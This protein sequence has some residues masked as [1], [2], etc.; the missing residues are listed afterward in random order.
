MTARQN[1]NGIMAKKP[2]NEAR[3]RLLGRLRR[4]KFAPFRY[5]A[6]DALVARVSDSA[7]A[8]PAVQARIDKMLTSR[9]YPVGGGYLVKLPHDGPSVPRD[10][11]FWVE[12]GGWDHEHCDACN[13][14][15]LVGGPVWCT[16]RGS[17]Q[18]LCPYCYRR[19]AQLSRA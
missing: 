4:R 11:G 18:K 2:A 16:V 7:P 8:P 14:P 9:W 13:R 3:R 1:T 5:A 6:G 12:P 19:V 15:I 17:F 10:G